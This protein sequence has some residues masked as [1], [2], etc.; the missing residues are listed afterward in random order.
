MPY[1][2]PQ[3]RLVARISATTACGGK[4]DIDVILNP[5]S[6]RHT[7]PWPRPIG[8]IDKPIGDILTLI[9]RPR[10]SFRSTACAQFPK[11]AA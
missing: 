5:P 3:K 9:V 7:L 2:R 8:G 10:P 6:L 11:H 4:R 1:L